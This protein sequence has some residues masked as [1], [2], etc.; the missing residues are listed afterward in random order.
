MAAR[1]RCDLDSSGRVL[2]LRPFHSESC[3]RAVSRASRL[4]DVPTAVAVPS[5]LR[6]CQSLRGLP[7]CLAS[8]AGPCVLRFTCADCRRCMETA[9]IGLVPALL[10]RQLGSGTWQTDLWTLRLRELLLAEW[11]EEGLTPRLCTYLLSGCA[12]KTLYP[13]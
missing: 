8:S 12:H 5:T 13:C 9:M 6:P 1:L 10:A 11:E 7:A 4:P 2:R 3:G